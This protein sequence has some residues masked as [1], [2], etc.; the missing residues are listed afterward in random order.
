MQARANIHMQD[1]KLDAANACALT[2]AHLGR[3][4]RSTSSARWRVALRSRVHLRLHSYSRAGKPAQPHAHSLALAHRHARTRTLASD[5]T[6][7]HAHAYTPTHPDV[8]T[9]THP[10]VH[11]RPNMLTSTRPHALTRAHGQAHPYTRSHASA[12]ARNRAHQLTIA[13]AISFLSLVHAPLLTCMLTD[14]CARADAS[15]STHFRMDAS[16]HLRP[17]QT[18]PPASTRNATVVH[19]ASSEASAALEP[20]LGH[21]EDKLLRTQYELEELR[22]ACYFPTVDGYTLRF[23]FGDNYIG[24]K[25]LLLEQFR[26][27]LVLSVTPGVDGE[28]NAR[29][30]TARA[31]FLGTGEGDGKEPGALLRFLG[32]GVSLV[33]RHE[34]LGVSIL[35]N[36]SLHRA[37]VSARFVADIPLVYLHKRRMWKIERGFK[38]ELLRFRKEA[39]NAKESGGPDAL[40]R[41]LVQAPTRTERPRVDSHTFLLKRARLSRTHLARSRSLSHSLPR[42]G[43]ARGPGARADRAAAR[44]APR[45]L[46]TRRAAW[47]RAQDGRF[48]AGVRRRARRRRVARAPAERGTHRRRIA[49]DPSAESARAN[50]RRHACAHV[51]RAAALC[52]RKRTKTNAVAENASR[53]TCTS[54]TEAT[55]AWQAAGRRTHLFCSLRLFRLSHAATSFRHGALEGV[56]CDSDVSLLDLLGVWRVCDRSFTS[57]S[58]LVGASLLRTQATLTTSPT[59]MSPFLHCVTVQRLL[60]GGGGGLRA[61][62]REGRQQ[63]ASVLRGL[64]DRE[65]R[66]RTLRGNERGKRSRLICAWSDDSSFCSHLRLPRRRLRRAFRCAPSTRRS[67]A[68]ATARAT[69]RSSSASPMHRRGPRRATPPPSPLLAS[70]ARD[71]GYKAAVARR[72]LEWVVRSVA[73]AL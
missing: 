66:R 41:M 67:A 55:A 65:K 14:T 70:R 25:E 30:P 35:P 61:T 1:Y 2:N 6:H 49:V 31:T 57:A 56:R 60:E 24:F 4:A 26:G 43:G 39:S 16:S 21:L 37:D 51:H 42:A 68:T 13:V 5:Y 38:L 20:L 58:D 12:R 48:G 29:A 19:S 69:P 47:A 9:P 36:L 45:R 10:N 15:S 71:G 52:V 64:Q 63:D 50:L 59:S 27:T 7:A 44:P 17:S 8:H 33:A 46:P 72:L 32:E 34:M 53:R 11:T 3:L 18:T 28:S 22:R 23:S 40:L 62:W 73:R 54:S